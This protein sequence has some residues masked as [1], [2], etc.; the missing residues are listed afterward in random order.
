MSLMQKFEAKFAKAEHPEFR[1]G[2]TVKV[3][4]RVIEG[5][6]ERAQ[7]FQGVIVNLRG[8]STNRTFT[9]RKV[10]DGIGVER[11]FPIHSPNISKIV[12]AR[13]GAVKRAKLFYLRG[14]TGKAAR[15]KEKAIQAAPETSAK[16]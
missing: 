5:D 10:S 4:V 8:S 14:K 16:K 9:V 3:Y 15:L 13:Q 6:K 2:D 1:P 7:M 12:V 11:I